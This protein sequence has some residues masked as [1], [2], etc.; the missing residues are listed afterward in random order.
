MDA[1]EDLIAA[2]PLTSTFTDE[3]PDDEP[4]TGP[5]EVGD[6]KPMRG[7]AYLL[8]WLP[9]ACDL[10]G[11]TVRVVV[12]AAAAVV[13]SRCAVRQ[14]PPFF[15]MCRLRGAQAGGPGEWKLRVCATRIAHTY[16]ALFFSILFSPSGPAAGASFAP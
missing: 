11:T 4:F 7:W 16:E 3:I 10:T 5:K 13:G 14:K 2:P 9:A 15:S 6:A 1:Q 8:L 12:V